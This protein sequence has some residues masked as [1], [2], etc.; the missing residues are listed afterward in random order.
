[1]G[2]ISLLIVRTR[3]PFF[4]SSTESS[5]DSRYLFMS[6]SLASAAASTIF[7]RHSFASA[8]SSSGTGRRSN[9]IPWVAS[10]Q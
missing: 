9:F 3:R 1:M 2:T 7:S 5:P 6:S 8:A 10:S 4:S